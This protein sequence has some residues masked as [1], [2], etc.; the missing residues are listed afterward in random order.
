MNWCCFQWK[1][2][3]FIKIFMITLKVQHLFLKT[4]NAWFH[5]GG[6]WNFACIVHCVE[7]WR[8]AVLHFARLFEGHSSLLFCF[9]L[10]PITCRRDLALK[11]TFFSNGFYPQ[12]F[13]SSRR[14]RNNKS[15]CF[16]DLIGCRN[17]KDQP[18]FKHF[19]L[20]AQICSTLPPYLQ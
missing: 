7:H 3:C 11:K 14:G 18:C 16:A 12:S 1:L 13:R 6:Y 19:A 8:W 17:I 20:G 2:M 4:S 9:R 5:F 15:F 10:K